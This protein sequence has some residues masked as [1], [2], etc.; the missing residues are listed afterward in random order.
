MN[1]EEVL[2]QIGLDEKQS[3]VY[4]AVL[5]LGASGVTAIAQKAGIERTY[6]YAILDELVKQGLVVKNNPKNKKSY[7]F[8][9]SPEK[10]EEIA[11]ERLEAVQRAIPQM[12]SVY[13][14]GERQPI[15]RFYQGVEGIKKMYR[16]A[17]TARSK[18]ILGIINP[19]AAYKA[20]GE[21]LDKETKLAAISNVKVEDLVVS[22]EQSKHYLEK[23]NKLGSVV[24]VLPGGMNFATDFLI[25]DDRVDLIS[26]EDPMHG[27]EIE[28]PEIANAF[29]QIHQALQK[30]CK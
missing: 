24:K 10:I 25:Y 9:V 15:V 21:V 22:G 26:F 20:L 30:V 18:K 6:C 1:I 28:S 29:R 14:V 7:F 17:Q 16:N 11:K 13:E 23:A 12:K 4:Y 27:Y 8:V 2:K 5:R 3:K 19:T